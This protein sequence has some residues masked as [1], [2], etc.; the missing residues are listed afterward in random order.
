MGQT[1]LLYTSG[2]CCL[3]AFHLPAGPSWWFACMRKCRCQGHNHAVKLQLKAQGKGAGV[4]PGEE[5]TEQPHTHSCH[6]TTDAWPDIHSLFPSFE[7]CV[8]LALYS[9]FASYPRTHVHISLSSR[10]PLQCRL[11]LPVCR[12]FCAYRTFR[13]IPLEKQN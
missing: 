6:L 4:Q 13:R 10:Q 1:E 9:V 7:A 2:L 3:R 12:L 5:N 11:L 8:P